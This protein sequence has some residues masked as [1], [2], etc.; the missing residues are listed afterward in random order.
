LCPLSFSVLGFLSGLNMCMCCACCQSLCE[1]IHVSTLL[2]LKE[3]LWSHP[4]HLALRVFPLLAYRSLI[5]EGQEVNKVTSFNAESSN[6]SHFAHYP[7]G[8]CVKYHIV[9]KN[10][11]FSD[12]GWMTLFSVNITICSHLVVIL[13]LCFFSRIIVVGLFSCRLMTYLASSSLPF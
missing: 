5:L 11:S 13:L 2:C 3:F 4:S 9:I 10:K 6:I 7:M 12:E 1:F 8:L